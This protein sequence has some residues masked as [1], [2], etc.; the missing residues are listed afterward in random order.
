MQ[1]PLWVPGE[2]RSL[3]CCFFSRCRFRFLPPPIEAFDAAERKTLELEKSHNAR[4]ERGGAGSAVDFD[5]FFFRPTENTH[6]GR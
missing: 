1:I 6:L 4:S 5:F 2:T 3:S